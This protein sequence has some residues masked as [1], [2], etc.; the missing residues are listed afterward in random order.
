MGSL[1][2]SNCCSH[3]PLCLADSSNHLLQLPAPATNCG[4]FV[5]SCG[6]IAASSFC[7]HSQHVCGQF[8]QPPAAASSSSNQL[9]IPR[10]FS[11]V[12]WQHPAAAIIHS[13]CVAD[14]SNHLLQLPAQAASCPF[15]VSSRGFIGSIQRLQ[16]FAA[17][18]W[19]IPA[20]ICCGLQLKQLAAD[21]S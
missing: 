17:R 10:R 15:L 19:L 20:I 5:G 8:Q 21:S 12:H 1:A 11:W 16:S 3:S 6:L 13:M 14:S 2:A 9:P 18:V 7:S 4:C